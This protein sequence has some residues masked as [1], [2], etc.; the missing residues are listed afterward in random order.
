[1]AW[2]SRLALMT[3][4]TKCCICVN[5]GGDPMKASAADTTVAGYSVCSGHVALMDQCGD[6]TT[7]LAEIKRYPQRWAL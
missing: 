6:I 1:M 7:A 3:E 2:Q 5:V 4:V